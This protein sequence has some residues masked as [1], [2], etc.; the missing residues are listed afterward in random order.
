MSHFYGTLRGRAKTTATRTGHRTTGLRAIA[1]SWQGAVQVDL[2]VKDEQDMARVRLVPWKGAGTTRILY[3]G[4]IDEA[5][6]E[7]TT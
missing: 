5:D 2:Y 6:A 3:D 7:A 1:A 4:P